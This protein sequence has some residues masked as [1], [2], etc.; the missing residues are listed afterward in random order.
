MTSKEKILKLINSGNYE[1]ILLGIELSY[2]LDIREF[3]DIF[4]NNELITPYKGLS[5]AFGRKNHEYHMFEDGYLGNLKISK[6]RSVFFKD[7]SRWYYVK[8]SKT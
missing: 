5:L 3:E 2:N 4:V 8:Y 1:D 6:N 7:K